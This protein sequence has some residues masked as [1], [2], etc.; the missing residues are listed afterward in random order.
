LTQANL[1]AVAGQFGVGTNGDA[2][3]G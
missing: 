2:C 3:F 1:G